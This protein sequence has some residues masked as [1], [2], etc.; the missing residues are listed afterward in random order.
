[1][2]TKKTNDREVSKHMVYWLR[3]IL[4]G[5]GRGVLTALDRSELFIDLRALNQR[6]QDVENGVAAPSVGMLLEKLKLFL[7]CAG[8]S[9]AAAVATE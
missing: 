8:A 1:M 3:A 9:Y 2:Y 7:I 6:V 4:V 5:N